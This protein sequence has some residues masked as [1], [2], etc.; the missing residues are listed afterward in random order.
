VPRLTLLLPATAKFAGIAL[1]AALAKALGRADRAAHAA[2]GH[3]QLSR[4]FRLLPNRWSDAAL[5]RVADGDAGDARRNA[6]LRADPAYIRPDINGARLLGIGDALGIEQ[7]DVDAFLPALRPLFG[8]AGFILDAPTPARW[9]LRLPREAT[10]PDFASPDEALGDDVFEHDMARANRDAPE[11][12]RWRV[13]SSEA[14]VM[15]HNHPRNAERIAAGKPP[16]NS[17]WFWGGGLLPDGI[18]SD[19]PTLYSDDVL[20]HGVARI[21]KLKAMPM[22]AYA[23]ADVDDALLDLRVARDP[24]ATVER[25]LVPIAASAPTRDVAFDFADGQVFALRASQR[26]RIWRRPQARFTA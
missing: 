19:S 5:A 1:P 22:R 3:A 24:R 8:D 23:N 15:L 13:L 18:A 20:L 10:L 26:W 2:G 12:R 17:L 25:W 6:W 11:A 4:H 9:Y 14:Q 21:G 16:V 7:A